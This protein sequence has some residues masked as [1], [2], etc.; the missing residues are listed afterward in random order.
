MS[1]LLV[2]DLAPETIE[3]LKEQAKQQGRSA[4]EVKHPR[5]GT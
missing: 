1:Q 3:K 2:R 5:G 4:G